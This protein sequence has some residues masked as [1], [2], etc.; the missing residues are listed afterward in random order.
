MRLLLAPW[1]AIDMTLGL[2]RPHNRNV[3]WWLWGTGNEED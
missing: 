2:T 1:L 3:P